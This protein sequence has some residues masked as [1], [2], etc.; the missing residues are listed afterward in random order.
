MLIYCDDKVPNFVTKYQI[1]M[2]GGEAKYLNGETK[3]SAFAYC[4]LIIN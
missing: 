2:F 4:Q 3:A 1:D